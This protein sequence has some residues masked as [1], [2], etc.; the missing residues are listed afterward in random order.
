MLV[1]I[2]VFASGIVA[3]ISRCHLR[4]RVWPASQAA[5]VEATL[6]AVPRR[7]HRRIRS[8]DCPGHVVLVCLDGG[9]VVHGF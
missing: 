9:G 2:A 8:Q 6:V 7:V 1:T 5:E 4:T 3:R